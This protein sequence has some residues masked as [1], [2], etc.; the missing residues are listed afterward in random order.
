MELVTLS[1]EQASQPNSNGTG[2]SAEG[3]ASSRST[4]GC[5]IRQMPLSVRRKRRASK[6]GSSPTTRPSGI[7]TPRSTMTFVSRADRPISTPGNTT[8]CSR[9]APL[10]T[11]VRV[12]RIECRKTAPDTMQ[13]PDRRESVTSALWSSWVTFAGGVISALVQIGHSSS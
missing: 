8:A 1:L 4:I 11:R 5:V 9:W 7:H 12:N 6:S 13:P 2:Q 10:Q 3:H